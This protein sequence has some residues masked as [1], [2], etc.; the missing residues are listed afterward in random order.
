GVRSV[1]WEPSS[2]QHLPS[3]WIMSLL[4]ARDGT[5]WIGTGKGL[6]SW[7]NGKLT[8]YR[9]LDGI[10]V[11]T[12]LE[13]RNG[14][15][16][17]GGFGVPN[18]RLCE[19]QNGNAHCYGEDGS[20][21]HGVLRL[22]EDSK[23]YL[24]AGVEKGLWR[25]KPGTS[26]FYPVPDAL[27]TIHAFVEDDAGALLFTNRAE[28]D[29]LIN[30]KVEPFSLPGNLRQLRIEGMLR[31]HDGGLW[32]A[33]ERGVLHVHQG[34][35]DVFAR[36]DGL[37]GDW[38]SNLF[39]DREGDIWALTINGLDRFR[40]LAVATVSV[41]QGL[42]STALSSVL[43]E[44]DGSVL[45]STPG[46]LDRWDHGRIA[47]APTGSP[48]H[49]GKLIGD[50]PNSLFRDGRGRIWISTVHGLGYL[51]NNR[52][53]RLDGVPGD[54]VHDIA[55]DNAD[56]V[57]VAEQNSGLFRVSP[58]GEVQQIPWA[59]L[60]HKD[61]AYALLADPVRGG[62]WLG[63]FQGGIAYFNDGGI[64]ASYGAA[65]GLGEGTITNFQLD[66]DGTLWVATQGGLSRLKNG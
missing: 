6:A 12:I 35:T 46:G 51:A 62:L 37:S 11:F 22:Y 31:D 63:F 30:G 3:N 45:L 54:A 19:I 47:V 48:K 36:S 52:F 1:L 39:E 18:G 28:I 21:G 57:W 49:D 40:E 17:A 24:W 64:R 34:R 38:V 25:W 10:F 27:D 55:E 13:D 2:T 7:K 26:K 53:V 61:F 8:H 65:D 4:G 44:N 56:N 9:E 60:G 23:G 32:L 50:S 16:W 58:R 5:L 43:V 42:S 20:L 33:T 14:E 15:V 59:G 41:D 29:R 66:S